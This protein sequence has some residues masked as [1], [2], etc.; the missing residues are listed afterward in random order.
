LAR[1]KQLCARCGFANPR[2]YKLHTF[3]H[4][5][6]SMCARTNV[7]HRYALSWMGHSSSDILD[8][9]YRQFD[10]VADTAMMTVSYEAEPLQTKKEK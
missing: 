1:L 5:F 3:R 7:S 4:V 10:D 9:Y 2:Q 6:A 8:L